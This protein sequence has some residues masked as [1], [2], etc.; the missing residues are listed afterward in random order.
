MADKK[1]ERQTAKEALLRKTARGASKAK[2]GPAPKAKS[3]AKPKPAPKTTPAPKAWKSASGP[4]SSPRSRNLPKVLV[5]GIAGRLGRLLAKKLHR[6]AEVHGVDRRPFEGCPKDIVMHHIDL[7]KK[8]CEDLFRL[9]GYQAVFHLGVIHD[10]RRSA[11]EHHSFN[12]RGTMK[13]LEYC[14]KYNVPKVVLLS[15]ANIYGPSHTNPF[16][17]TEDAPLLA[18][19]KFPD[20]R[21]LIELD[22]LAQSFF[23]K[24][25]ETETV[26]LRPTHILGSHVR[27]GLAR[28]L[29]LKIIPKVMG[30][31]PMIQVIHEEDLVDAIIMAMRP[32]VRGIFNLAGPSVVPF[33]EVIRGVGRPTVPVPQ[34]MAKMILSLLWDLKLT[35]FRAP[36]VDYAR[37]I[38][39]V[40]TARAREI[41]GF[42]PRRSI[43]ETLKSMRNS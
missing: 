41:L 4:L 16:F 20:I 24:H 10:P 11:E 2:A 36:Q 13:I 1:H 3:K 43:R 42:T 27:Q 31:D 29:R 6:I 7:R 38:C 23:W 22:M 28:Y 40:D 30:F 15:T 35:D 5:T 26:I 8:R 18:G 32:G 33:S 39:T 25:A 37:F 21:D 34:S 9:T 17:L 19:E 12:L 14:N